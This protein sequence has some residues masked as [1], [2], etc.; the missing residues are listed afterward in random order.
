MKFTRKDYERIRKMDRIQLEKYI[1]NVYHEGFQDGSNAG[2]KADFKI[3]LV[4]V[5]QATKGI[6]DKTI[7]KVLN[8]LK[9]IK[10]EA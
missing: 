2:E 7:D 3:K 9:E 6:G 8:T 5:L 4:Q 10:G 1:V